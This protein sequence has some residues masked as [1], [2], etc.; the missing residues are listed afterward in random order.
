MTD[1]QQNFY[2]MVKASSRAFGFLGLLLG[3][4]GGVLTGVALKGIIGDPVVSGSGALMFYAA[5]GAS[6]LITLYVMFNYVTMNLQI[7][8]GV[9]EIRI[10]MKSAS[11]NLADI[12]AVRV[13]EPKSR[14]N[15]VA[16]QAKGARKILQM[17]SVLGVGS[18]VEIDVSQQ[19]EGQTQTWFISSNDPSE[20]A[21]KLGAAILAHVDDSTSEASADFSANS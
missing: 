9:F 18:G 21:E 10:G 4:T 7:S 8:T 6:T 5:F 19:G 15:R 13:A 11:V 17:W 2:Q 1:Q 20:L 14:M 12:S 3:V 16:S